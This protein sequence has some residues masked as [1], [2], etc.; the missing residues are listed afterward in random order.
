MKEKTKLLPKL[1]NCSLK[2]IDFCFNA[3]L[4]NREQVKA[5]IRLLKRADIPSK[6][7]V[8]TDKNKLLKDGF[9]VYNK[10]TIEI[11]IYDK[12]KQIKKEN[13]KKTVFSDEDLKRA[14]NIL[15]IEIR[16][17]DK[18][19]KELQ[20]KYRIF[21]IEEFFEYSDKIGHELYTYYLPKFFG[22]GE[23]YT[24]GEAKERIKISEY[25]K[26]T[27]EFM[28]EFVSYCNSSR[29]GFLAT[30]EFNNLY[31]KDK[32]K[33]IKEKFDE[34]EASYI[35]IPRRDMEL[36]KFGLPTLMELYNEFSN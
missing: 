36:F 24:L 17:Q 11:S 2:R 33:R 32:V 29:H 20:K 23:I 16:C 13:N 22:T 4:D 35:T 15:R 9:T 18:K 19:I 14:K 27:I 10:N 34:I 5:Y 6:M 28:K 30:K 31:G 26:P 7:K 21:T 25:R 12:Y 3:L 1:A 8:R